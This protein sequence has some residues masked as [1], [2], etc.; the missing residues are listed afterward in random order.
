MQ[1]QRKQLNN[2][3]NKDNAIEMLPRV[4]LRLSKTSSN[5]YNLTIKFNDLTK[6]Q[7]ASL[8]N[9]NRFNL[10]LYLLK[11]VQCNESS[12]LDSNKLFNL[13]QQKIIKKKLNINLMDDIE[14][15][16]LNEK[17]HFDKTYLLEVS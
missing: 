15:F 17:E 3:R 1:F 14:V 13:N 6:S 11:N 9:E 7:Q 8:F 5:K 16:E 12:I 10:N 4:C 2:Q